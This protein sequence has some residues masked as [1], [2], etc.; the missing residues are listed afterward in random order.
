[1]ID[2]LTGDRLG[3]AQRLPVCLFR[4]LALLPDNHG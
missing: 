2:D 1:M 4:P 3:Q